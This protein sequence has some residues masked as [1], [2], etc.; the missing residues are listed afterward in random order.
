MLGDQ[1]SIRYEGA[2]QGCWS[3]L[4]SLYEII[5]N[6]LRLF[7]RGAILGSILAPKILP[8][9]VQDPQA[10]LCWDT[11][12]YARIRWDTLGYVGLRWDMLGDAVI[13]W[14][15]LGYTV[16]RWDTFGYARIR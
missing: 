4:R 13:R 2:L 6:A 1:C 16:I 15:T 3:L 11:L 5:I 8:R 9:G 7:S 14:D 10:R 12:S